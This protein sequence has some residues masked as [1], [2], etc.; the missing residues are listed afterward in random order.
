MVV[1]SN[2]SILNSLPLNKLMIQLNKPTMVLPPNPDGPTIVD[3]GLFILVSDTVWN[4]ATAPPT[5][6]A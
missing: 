6:I 2:E 1:L 3:I 5:A 4:E